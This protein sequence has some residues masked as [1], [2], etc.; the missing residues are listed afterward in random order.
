MANSSLSLT[1]LD[2]D[3]LKT[4]FKNYLKSQTVFKDYNFDASNLSTLLDVMSYN[5]YLN[6][7]YLNMVASE[8]F[9]DSAQKLDSVVSHAKELNYVPTSA[10]SSEAVIG[11]SVVTSNNID[12][13][14]LPKGTL[15]TGVNSNGSY[16]FT[17]NEPYTYTQSSNN[18]FNITD[19]KI[20]E[21]TFIRDAFVVDS[22]IETQKFLL[23]N[24]N[25]DTSSLIITV[26]ESGVS[27]I[28]NKKETLFGLSNTSNIYFLQGAQNQ[29]YEI[30]FGDG[31]FGRI[32]DNL[33]IIIAEYRVSSG[34]A[35][36]GI[37]SFLPLTNLGTVN[38]G[39]VTPSAITVSSNSSSGSFPQSIESIR[40]SAPRYF[41]TQQRAVAS[42]DYT[43]LV[44]NQFGGLLDDV[45]VYGGETLEPKQYGRVVISLK[46]SGGTIAPDYLKGQVSNYLADYI[47]LPTRVVISDPEYLYLS[48]NST[49]QYD[50]TATTKL[51]I[52]LAGNINSSIKQYG[53]DH[54]GK[55]GNDF[56][57]SK[58]VTHIDETDPSIVSN[59][60]DV[61]IIKRVS[62]LINYSTSFVIDYNNP[63]ESES[64][65][66][67]YTK[68]TAL[69]DEP[70]L[71]SSA[72]TYVDTD[73]TQ[74][75]YSYFRDDNLGVIIVYTL[76]N[77]IFTILNRSIGSIDYATGLV[78]I[79][80][81]TTSYYGDYISI[82]MTP[83][84]KDV[85][86][87]KQKILLID[88]VDVVLNVIEELK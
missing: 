80:E 64:E 76:I 29:Q 28:F 45:S 15:F 4:D 5:T 52:V 46:P 2:F 47:S 84:N 55:F 38:G 22:T 88:P 3:S 63:A 67:G 87:G 70:M 81:F 65:S 58:F 56:R 39:T 68:T 42:D 85:I 16:S 7:F 78:R 8:M 11:F 13:L 50:N 12:T 59:N 30:V 69:S 83:I 57:Y 41:A 71:T 60:T 14:S 40:F 43:T 21:G 74:Y 20:Y 54:L 1:S 26:V 73:G 35:S 86:I 19:L 31:F 27:T 66:P 24:P 32:P 61:A 18:T 33:A 49:I 62:P 72:F 6:S 17:T 34:S 44:L 79:N 10:K 48:I 77:G 23:S 9:L 82:Y 37:N 25:I 53:I 75:P 51:P 36:D